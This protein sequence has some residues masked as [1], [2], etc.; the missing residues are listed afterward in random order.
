MKISVSGTMIHLLGEW[1]LSGL[2]RV[3]IGSLAVPFQRLEAGGAKT[4]S[5]DCRQ[6]TA[7]DSIGLMVLDGLLHIPKFRGLGAELVRIPDDLRQTF[8]NSGLKFCFTNNDLN[9]P[10]LKQEPSNIVKGGCA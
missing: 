1:T 5:I 6:V 2:T 8:Q 4:V 3:T 10:K 9:S 7:I